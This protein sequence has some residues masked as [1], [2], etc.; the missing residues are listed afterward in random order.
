MRSRQ[1][2]LPALVAAALLASGCASVPGAGDYRGEERCQPPA[3]KLLPDPGR[4]P[5][6]FK[7]RPGGGGG[8]VVGVN[9]GDPGNGDRPK[10]WYDDH[11]CAHPA[12]M[13][14]HPCYNDPSGPV[15]VE[16]M[17]PD[18]TR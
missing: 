14:G 16:P 12:A 6:F 18:Y 8:P 2:T 1:T 11:P 4:C 3:G 5:E 10:S 9:P 15:Y 7:G 17:P 13:N